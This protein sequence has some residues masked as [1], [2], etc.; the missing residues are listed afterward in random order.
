MPRRVR[1]RYSI[2]ALFVVCLITVSSAVT[3]VSA[4]QPN[5]SAGEELIAGETPLQI[6]GLVAELGA[7]EFATR[8]R[9]ADRLTQIGTS[10]IPHLRGVVASSDDPE[11][12]LR[13]S[14]IVRQLTDGDLQ[15]QID[16]F[17]AG[18]EIEFEGWRSIRNFFGDTPGS[19]DLFIE[20]MNQHPRLT[21][22][23][24]GETRDRAVALEAVI[25][26]VRNATTIERRFPNRADVFALLL[27]GV[28]QNLPA[29]PALEAQIMMVLNQT[30]V[31]EIR[32]DWQ[33][34]R[35]FESLLGIWMTRSSIGNRQE[36]LE[37]GMRMDLKATLALALRTLDES[38]DEAILTT[39]LQVISRF[40][41]VEQ[42]LVIRRLLEDTRPIERRGL[43]QRPGFTSQVGDVAMVAVAIL[44]K[45]DL[46]E[47]GF[48]EVNVHPN[49]G[50]DVQNIGFYE[51]EKREAAKSKV[52]K[53]FA[54]EVLR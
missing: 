42:A 33:L 49:I 3:P 8:E 45:A 23:L 9:A 1:S 32:R 48:S 30:A 43:V 4:Q 38:N 50:F 28:D 10:V 47:I 31:R 52:K 14:E 16:G 19:R 54:P 2:S 17:L 27:A 5:D 25:S 34:N 13:A 21:E 12:R 53:L 7:R 20:L 39:T 18:E 35:P 24:E 15:A 40:G 36:I 22:S 11:V 37:I 51:A 6:K 41:Q 26:G 46:N 44:L 29:N